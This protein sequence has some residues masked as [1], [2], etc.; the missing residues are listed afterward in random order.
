L[1]KEIGGFIL[2]MLILAGIFLLIFSA[3]FAI[4]NYFFPF[5]PEVIIISQTSITTDINH[6]CFQDGIEINCS[7]IDYPVKYYG[8]NE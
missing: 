3:V 5:E 4:T 8:G 2:L 6:K 7:Q 1:I